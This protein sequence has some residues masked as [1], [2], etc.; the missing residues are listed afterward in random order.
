MKLALATDAWLP[1]VNGVVRSLTATVD[2]LTRR[3]HAVET[4]TPDRFRTMPMPG[5]ASIRLAMAP[6]FG[7]RRMLDEAA[8]DIVHIATEGPIGWAARGWC[9]SRRVPFTSA[10]HTRFP[11]YAAVRTGLSA[12]CFWPILQ[13]FHAQSR[14]VMVSTRSLAS[15]LEGRGI[16]PARAWSRGIDHALFRPDGPRHPAMTALPGP[17]L[18]NVGRVAPEKN[19][20]AF[21]S[22]DTPGSKVVVG[23]G[24]AL[25]T[26]R[27]RYPHVLFLGAL[28]GAEL[29]GAY[30]AADC[31]VF[32]S[33][34]D[35][36]GLVLIEA[37]ACGTPVAAFPVTG[38]IDIVGLDG[39][40]VDHRVGWP[41]GALDPS[42]ARAIDGALTAERNDAAALGA[43]YSW[44]RATDQFLAAIEGALCGYEKALRSAA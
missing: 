31:F 36:F 4:I 13:R 6:R 12:E 34:T 33:L 3:G 2:H 8:P 40:G 43:L 25:E 41:A 18:L 9:L 14:A 15:E 39:R 11:E 17:V 24:P 30:R 1:Q 28:S 10:F 22:L 37:L 29:A 23:D 5:Y 38:P 35:T 44:D 26:L 27:R 32:P 42:L 20:E 7:L 21:L 16:G 19:L